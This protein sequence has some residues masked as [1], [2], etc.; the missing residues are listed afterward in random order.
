MRNLLI[1]LL[2]IGLLA[3]CKN[4]KKAEESREEQVIHDIDQLLADLPDPSAIPSILK[5]IGAQFG[6]SLVNSL[7]N[8]EKYKGDADK[9]AMNMGVYASDV[10]YLAS[11]GK[12]ELTMEYVKTCHT[13]GETLG[14]SAI[15]SQD[16]LDKIEAN[17]DNEDELSKLLRGMIVETSVQLEKDH[18]L[19]MAALALTGSFVEELY[20]AVNVIENFH[21][22]GMSAADEKAKVEP[23]VKLV[24]DQEQPLL[25]LIELL[26]DIPHDDTVLEMI[27][28][29]NIL[30][31]L[32]KGE[33]AEI[34]TKMSEDP[35]FVVDR[36]MMFG[37]TLEIERIRALIIE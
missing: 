35:D 28:M 33:L 17:L 27:T 18:H 31:K 32:Y 36:D 20:Q 7:S 22:A 37:V 4:T 16:L 13:I 12:S 21:E 9:L 15:Y 10:S 8:L 1:L 34:E 11:Y 3:G 6:D 2:A 14:D 30:D 5:S 25:D 24:L 26:K 19:S 23:L 29:M